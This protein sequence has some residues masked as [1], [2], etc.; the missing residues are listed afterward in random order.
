MITRAGLCVAAM[1]MAAACSNRVGH[2]EGQAT[3]EEKPMEASASIFDL[4]PRLVQ[5]LPFRQEDVASL[6]GVTLTRDQ[7]VSNNAFDVYRST[8]PKGQIAAVEVRQ[9]IEP[10]AGK[11]GIVILDLAGGT[12][13]KQKDAMAR[14]GDPGDILVPTPHQ[15]PDSPVYLVYKQKWGELRLGFA[16]VE[17]ECLTSIVLDATSS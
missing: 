3:T 12:C 15:P 17:P 14:F 9:R 13:I 1:A 11:S 6:T 2:Q 16:R 10:T 7:Q 8:G 5:K 4:I